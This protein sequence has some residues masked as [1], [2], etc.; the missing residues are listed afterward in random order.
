MADIKEDV[1]MGAKQNK[2]LP[3]LIVIILIVLVL[4]VS[5]IY[6]RLH[7]DTP[8][9]K[10]ADLNDIYQSEDGTAA[11]IAN[12]VLSEARAEW[13]GQTAYLN[14]GI[15]RDELNDHFYWD[16][17]EKLLLYTTANE[18]VRADAEYVSGCACFLRAG[19]E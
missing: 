18:V 2:K 1:T 12:G 14:L 4:A 5:F 11:V 16:D 10:M 9:D 13:R 15:V 19:Q 17:N 6:E 8:T 3:V 7:A